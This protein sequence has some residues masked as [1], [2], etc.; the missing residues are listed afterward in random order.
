MDIGKKI[1]ELREKKGWSQYRL[2]KEAGISQA[3]LSRIEV[4]LRI[5]NTASLQK[6]ANALGV[7]MS[8]F[9]DSPQD[10]YEKL[11]PA[12]MEKLET[13][14]MSKEEQAAYEKIKKMPPDE[15]QQSFMRTIEKFKSLSAGDQEA[16][17]K[18]IDSLYSRK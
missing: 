2:F 10:D 6:I 8:E 11:Y 1:I 3:A 9:D 18:L 15:R 4:G 16:L 17:A 5:P 13:M 12:V 7:S 14:D